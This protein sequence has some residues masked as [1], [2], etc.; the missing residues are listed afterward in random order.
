MDNDEIV[1]ERLK[2]IE[3]L[4]LM[5]CAGTGKEPDHKDDKGQYEIVN[6]IKE[7][8]KLLK[9]QNNNPVFDIPHEFIEQFF[10]ALF[11]YKG[12]A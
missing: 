9:E 10:K 8:L 12:E 7:S 3:K 1:L 5:Y 11:K 4:M 2:A 6:F